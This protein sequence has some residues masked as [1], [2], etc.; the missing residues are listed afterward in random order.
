MKP[1]GLSDSLQPQLSDAVIDLV[2]LT[3]NSK[4]E[5]SD[6][7]DLRPC[8]TCLLEKL[9]SKIDAEKLYAILFLAAAALYSDAS[10][11]TLEAAGICPRYVRAPVSL[12]AAD[13]WCS[14]AKG[15]SAGVEASPSRSKGDVSVD[16]LTK[17]ET[18]WMRSD[19]G[20][21]DTSWRSDVSAGGSARPGVARMVAVSAS[22]VA[23]GV[24]SG[25]AFASAAFDPIDLACTALGGRHL[26]M[27]TRDSSSSDSEDEAAATSG[28]IW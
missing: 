1:P 10:P 24:A 18:E 21:A 20:G 11:E 19:A 9:S 22:H 4:A 17:A 15:K 12:G 28:T 7:A 23:S 5:T 3:D 27:I 2:F 8:R 6:Q 13:A 16:G 26:S 14:P 25:A